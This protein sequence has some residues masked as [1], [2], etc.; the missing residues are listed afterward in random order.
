MFFDYDLEVCGWV[1]YLDFGFFWFFVW[2]LWLILYLD[3]F[4]F[5]LWDWN[6]VF[7]CYVVFGR[8]FEF[9]ILELN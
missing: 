6:F 3:L 2:I 1:V 7:R 8:I 4:C 9:L 5:W